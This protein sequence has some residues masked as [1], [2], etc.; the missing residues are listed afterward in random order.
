VCRQMEIGDMEFL[1]AA[2]QKI[3]QASGLAAILGGPAESGAFVMSRSA[4]V[5][6]LDL[7]T[8]LKKVFEICPGKGGGSP[9]FVRAQLA[10]GRG[11]PQAMEIAGREAA[12]SANG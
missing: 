12:M 2:A 5:Q 4:D 1:V 10:D 6:T 8:V 11:M 7:R 9:T 3:A